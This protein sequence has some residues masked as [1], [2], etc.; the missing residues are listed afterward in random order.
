MKKKAV[1]LI[2]GLLVFLFGALAGGLLTSLRMNTIT[3]GR[4]SDTRLNDSLQRWFKETFP[5]FKDAG[6]W[7][8][9]FDKEGNPR[10]STRSFIVPIHTTMG[11][12]R[13]WRKK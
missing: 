2:G 7:I 13:V 5:Q 10:A 8:I 6:T 3:L 4:L 1:W 9:E 12:W 11:R